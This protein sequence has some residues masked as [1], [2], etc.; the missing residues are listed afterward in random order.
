MSRKRREGALRKALRVLANN[1]SQ[2]KR[3]KKDKSKRSIFSVKDLVK[4][5]RDDT[6]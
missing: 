2:R 1:M 3:L 5:D 6:R 4:G